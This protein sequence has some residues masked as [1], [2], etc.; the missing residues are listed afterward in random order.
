MQCCGAVIGQGGTAD[1]SDG[2]HSGTQREDEMIID[3]LHK[4][5]EV[6]VLSLRPAVRPA[7]VRQGRRRKAGKV[8]CSVGIRS[9]FRCEQV[10]ME[11]S[12]HVLPTAVTVGTG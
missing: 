6:V 11:V 9:R 8:R 3:K 10:I 7:K 5:A 4:V 12:N 2:Q 1:A